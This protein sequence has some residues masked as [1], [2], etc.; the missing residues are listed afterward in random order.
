MFLKPKALHWFADNRGGIMSS[1][2]SHCASWQIVHVPVCRCTLDIFHRAYYAGL[3]PA[4]T[5]RIALTLS[6]CHV[7]KCVTR[8]PAPRESIYTTA[9]GVKSCNIPSAERCD[10]KTESFRQFFLVL[11]EAAVEL[12]KLK[13]PSIEICLWKQRVK[14]SLLWSFSTN[15]EHCCYQQGCKSTPCWRN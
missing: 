9:A 2:Y 3:L 4:L 14:G 15:P 10:R 8:V 6:K 11:I 13:P 1:L 7:A 12:E 5:W